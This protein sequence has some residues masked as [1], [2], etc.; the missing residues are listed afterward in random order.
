[1]AELGLSL[2]LQFVELLFAPSHD[3]RVL[4]LNHFLHEKIDL[5]VMGAR[6][7]NLGLAKSALSTHRK[8]TQQALLAERVSAWRRHGLIH[9]LPADRALELL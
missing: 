2:L 3:V 1:M 7:E 4:L 5:Q 6:L 9:Q 8:R